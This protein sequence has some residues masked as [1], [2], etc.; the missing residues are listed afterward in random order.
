MRAIEASRKS[1]V[2]IQASSTIA[3]AAMLMDEKVVGALVVL[4]GDHPVGIVTD[5]DLAVRVLARHRRS[6]ARIDSVMSTNLVTY[7]ANSEVLDA[8]KVFEEKA[9]RRL[10]LVDNGKV[11][12]MLTVDDLFIDLV[13]DLAKLVRPVTGQVIFGHPEPRVPLWKESLTKTVGAGERP[14]AAE[15]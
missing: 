10:P 11:V 8:V 13:S 4:E 2:T 15:S 9:L 1:P 5:R 12:G 14:V 6:D 3:Q 7:D